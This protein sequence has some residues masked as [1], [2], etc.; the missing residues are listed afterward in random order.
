[1]QLHPSEQHCVA[2][3]LTLLLQRTNAASAIK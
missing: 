2:L 3:S 1:M